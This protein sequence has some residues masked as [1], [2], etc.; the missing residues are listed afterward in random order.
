MR[1][2]FLLFW[3]GLFLAAAA[4]GGLTVSSRL[5][6]VLRPAPRPAPPPIPPKELPD[7]EPPFVPVAGFAVS[8][9]GEPAL[10]AVKPGD[11][12][13]LAPASVPTL[14]PSRRLGERRYLGPGVL[15]PLVVSADGSTAAFTT[16]MSV[17]TAQGWQGPELV[18]WDIATAREIRRLA[19]GHAALG[20]LALSPDGGKLF[21]GGA[22]D[23]FP[24]AA[25]LRVWDV[26]TGKLLRERPVGSW[27]LSA[28]GKTLATV[29]VHIGT[30]DR[31]HCDEPEVP[32]RST[33]ALW[34]AAEFTPRAAFSYT[35]FVPTALAVSPD[36]SK[37]V[38]GRGAVATAFDAISGKALWSQNLVDDERYA[39]QDHAFVFAPDGKAIAT[40]NTHIYPGVRTIRS[41]D[42]MTGAKRLLVARSERSSTDQ[43]EVA[44]A[45]FSPDSRKLVVA[46]QD[47][48]VVADVATGELPPVRKPGPGLEAWQKQPTYEFIRRGIQPDD[49]EHVY[50]FALSADGKTA[51][52]GGWFRHDPCGLRIVDV[53]TR[54]VKYPPVPPVQIVAPFPPADE[55]PRRQIP[56]DALY[57]QWL[58]LADG[59]KFHWFGSLSPLR[60]V[61]ADGKME[62]LPLGDVYA[63]LF[64]PDGETLLTRGLIDGTREDDPRIRFR[65][66]ATGKAWAEA[67]GLVGHQRWGRTMALSADGRTLAA[68]H[69]DGGIW[70][71]EVATAKPRLR[72]DR[73]GS[74]E[75]FRLSFS[76]DGRYL[77]SHDRYALT[78]LVWDLAGTPNA[79][80]PD[81]VELAALWDALRGDDTAAAYRAVW[82]LA[83][84][85][86]EAVA[87]LRG[88]AGD[89]PAVTD[90]ARLAARPFDKDTVLARRFVE[91][92]QRCGTADAA[93]LLSE[94]VSRP[95]FKRAAPR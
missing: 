13:P 47:A 50:G 73:A 95:A 71:W 80:A 58:T 14:A 34:N 42:A 88:K 60:R 40:W 35:S 4:A 49:T 51:F 84:H 87:F 64:T 53:A 72:L 28:D 83:G 25:P 10:I 37:V 46:F 70:L 26:A 65:D 94:L 24:G 82:R 45:A 41:L 5:A 1:R 29:D 66:A 76:R 43:P 91:T 33:L 74:D 89:V 85:P 15:A 59:R 62:H 16:G 69:P 8:A 52:L 11:L 54:A 92:V 57:P 7:A 12:K 36:G 48:V 63:Y 56:W 20:R 93:L 18:V 67:P 79:A 68:L 9:T 75:L 19:L 81:A 39:G 31:M 22:R 21:A 38:C 86:A 77:M 6:S 55:F 27:A 2:R 78:G 32:W 61:H 44:G 17:N 3:L 30:F 23:T 90:A